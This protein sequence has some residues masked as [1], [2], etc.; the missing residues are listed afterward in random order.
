MSQ[1]AYKKDVII[2]L[3]EQDYTDLDVDDYDSLP[4]DTYPLHATDANLNAENEELDDTDLVTGD[5]RS[6]LMGLL[7][8]S[9]DST[10]NFDFDDDAFGLIREAF[11]D[12]T[13]V[14]AYYLPK[15]IDDPVG[16]GGEVASQSFGHSGDV[17]SLE[18][19]DITLP[20]K[21]PMD[22]LESS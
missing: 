9:I 16:Y 7:D 18:E 8:W 15:G 19:V 3:E 11:M 1:A 2:S 17:G 4:S 5:A 20:S 6:R 14:Y 13:S 10:V 12:R 21:G 22:V